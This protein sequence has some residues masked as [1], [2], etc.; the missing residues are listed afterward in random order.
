MPD[1]IGPD[2]E[3]L[4]FWFFLHHKS[5]LYVA[6][7]HLKYL[8]EYATNKKVTGN[9][10]MVPKQVS[11]VVGHSS[12]LSGSDFISLTLETHL[13]IKAITKTDWIRTLF[14]LFL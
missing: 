11:C 8:M 7:V 1:K 12:A 10:V 4:Q 9:L 14:I 3:K 13:A 5:P 2:E 6:S